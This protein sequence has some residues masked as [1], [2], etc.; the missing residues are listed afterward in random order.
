MWSFRKG[1]IVNY[2]VL[3]HPS[4]FFFLPQ[5]ML[6]Y[7]TSQ[8]KIHSYRHETFW[9]TEILKW[10]KK[11][12]PRISM[13][14][15]ETC[16]LK[17]WIQFYQGTSRT[18]ILH[19]IADVWGDVCWLEDLT[20][21]CLIIISLKHLFVPQ[22]AGTPVTIPSV[23]KNNEKSLLCQYPWYWHELSLK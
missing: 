10:K 7:S 18:I 2:L 13:N 6:L 11:C 22:S 17:A 1:N 3:Q 15:N 20:V 12:R 21:C 23:S 14:I 8:H 5:V 9:K 4:F 16:L 19:Y